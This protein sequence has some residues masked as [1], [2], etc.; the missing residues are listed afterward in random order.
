MAII[1]KWR[2]I[3]ANIAGNNN[4]F[5][6]IELHDNSDCITKWGRV[7]EEGKAQSKTFPG[8]GES[9][10]NKKISEKKNKSNPDERYTEIRT[11][12]SAPGSGQGRIVQSQNLVEIA[13]REINSNSKD[14]ITLIERLA[15][16]NI[17][18]ITSQT[19]MT[20]NKVTGL[21]ETPLGIVTADAILEARDW[22]SKIGNFVVTND[23]SNHGFASAINQYM[24]LIPSD[25]GRQRVK[26]RDLFPALDSVQ[27]QNDLLDSL[28]GSLQMV[29]SAPTDSSPAPVAP[30]LFET[31]LHLCD[32]GKVF[33]K[34]N[35]A[36]NA[37]RQSIHSSSSLNIHKIYSVE[38]T[39]MANAYA[40]HGAKIGNVM[41]L[42]HGTRIGN[43]LS[44]LKSGFMIPPTNAGHCTGRLLGNGTYFS[45][46]STKSL[47][48]ATGTAPGQRGGYEQ[49]AFMF[50]NDVAMGKMYE[51]KSLN[52]RLPVSGYDSVF[53]RG[54]GYTTL[55]NN[56][57]VV[58]NTAQ[59]N[60][61]Y[62][63]EFK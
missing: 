61:R 39:K 49:F 1:K 19:T 35:K 21:F 56:E 57:M 7:A 43:L 58:Y 28:D 62:L 42:W 9:F 60:P 11:L 18:N 13:K 6:E 17:H 36:F 55:R 32:D 50:W 34:L 37:T 12:D 40:N 51:P 44:L 52:E 10:F 38:I 4:K 5:W 46:Q 25:F 24:R 26:P 22:L 47:N 23:W 15:A 14:T 53:A 2:G 29:L 3:C 27:K 31:T 8:M 30:K 54:G 16:A 45:D 41:E 48:Y 59:I 20:F 63:V 33:D